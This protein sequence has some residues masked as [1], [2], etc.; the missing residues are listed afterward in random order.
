[1]HFDVWESVVIF[2]TDSTIFSAYVEALLAKMFFICL[3]FSFY[4]FATLSSFDAIF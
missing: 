3:V 4:I 2:R 1:M